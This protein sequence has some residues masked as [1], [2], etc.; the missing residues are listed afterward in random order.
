M[1]SSKSNEEFEKII[2]DFTR[3]LE[4][5]FP[6]LS[7]NFKAVDFT[8]Y[9]EFC[10]KEYPPKFFQ[11]LYENDEI[12]EEDCFLLP[13]VNFSSL[14]KDETLSENSKKAIWKYLQ[15]VL[16]CVCNNSEQNESFGDTNLLFQAIN[17]EELQKKIA[18][19]MSEM[20]NI[21]TDSSFGMFDDNDEENENDESF[22]ISNNIFEKMAEMFGDMS[23]NPMGENGEIPEEMKE[24]FEKMKKE[25]EEEAKNSTNTD[26]E[27]SST[28]KSKNPFASFLDPEKM[29]DHLSSLMGGK[30]GSMAKEI[31]EEA[32]KEFSKEYGEVSQDDIIKEMMKN[33]AKILNLVK[34]IGG[35]LEEKIKSGEYK[36]SEL[37]EEAQELMG[38]M[39]DMPGLKQMMSSMGLNGMGGSG[40]KF[41][42]KNMANHMKQNM[43]EAKQKEAMREKL[44]RR[45]A[46][47]QK[48]AQEA[49]ARTNITQK[50]ENVFVWTDE[51]S[52]PSTP[53]KKSSKKASNSKKKKKSGKK[54]K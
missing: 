26:G 50:E 15:L 34:N 25:M 35:K 5:T 45:E 23:G 53:L 51:N 18:E 43:R 20:K 21:F 38:K 10:M 48:Q 30:I 7:D 33:P 14:M 8:E 32:T 27:E 24:M 44:A 16:F 52:N 36:E 54:K 17:E 49:A 11:I 31:A 4:T 46:E 1:D 29:G 37:M 47:R 39:K 2:L 41:D 12:F 19:T 9:H 6:E 40:G 42:F 28:N 13:N 22:D 3:D